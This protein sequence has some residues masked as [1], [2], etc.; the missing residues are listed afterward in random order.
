M[1][2]ITISRLVVAV[3][4][5]KDGKKPDWF[6]QT[7]AQTSALVGGGRGFSGYCLWA[8][9]KAAAAAAEE[10]AANKKRPPPLLAPSRSLS[11]PPHPR[12]KVD[13][14]HVQVDR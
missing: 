10:R 4:S 9:G 13:E 2:T 7:Y 6:S 1:A 5:R 3:V 11:L 14:L 12:R 8:G